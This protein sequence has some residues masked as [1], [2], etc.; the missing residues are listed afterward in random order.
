MELAAKAK[1]PRCQRERSRDEALCGLCGHLFSRTEPA[2]A[3][4]ASTVDT[5]AQQ[6]H[7]VELELREDRVLGLPASWF[8]LFIGA[9]TAPVFAWTPFLGYMG[10]FISSL[11]H[12]MGHSAVAWLFGMPAYPAIRLDGH[13]AAFHEEQKLWL[14]GLIAFGFAALTWRI[15]TPRTRYVTLG[16]GVGIYLALALTPGRELFHLVGGHGGELVFAAI[17]FARNL[18]GGH[19]SSPTERVLY[20]TVAW[21][22]LGSNLVLT[23]RLITSAAARFEYATNGSFGLRNDYLRLAEDLLHVPLPLVALAMTIVAGAVIPLV[24]VFHR[25][26]QR[27]LAAV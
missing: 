19:T 1:C 7:E 14:V 4:R 15:R 18:S 3:S 21:Y 2:Q 8:F 22:L 26:W 16:L 10:W 13:A 25:L 23:S 5:P 9:L 17:F 27:R 6:L 24:L 12:E 20:G 11:T